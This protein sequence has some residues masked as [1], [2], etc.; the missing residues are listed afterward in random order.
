MA[1]K[2]T[3]PSISL[4]S[5]L[6]EQA[7]TRRVA[8]L[9]AIAG[10]NTS[11]KSNFLSRRRASRGSEEYAS[12]GNACAHRLCANDNSLLSLLGATI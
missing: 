11:I 5:S 8:S 7:G 10:M 6:N 12:Y 9:A 4:V 1:Q 2:Q 3:L